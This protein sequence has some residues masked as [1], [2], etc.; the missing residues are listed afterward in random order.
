MQAQEHEAKTETFK[1]TYQE[2]L[3]GRALR[4]DPTAIYNF[5]FKNAG[6]VRPKIAYYKKAEND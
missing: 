5:T 1:Y 6:K 4:R 2:R 3:V